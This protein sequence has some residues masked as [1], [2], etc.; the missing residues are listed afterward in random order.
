M[1][2]AGSMRECYCTQFEGRDP[3]EPPPEGRE[4]FRHYVK[5]GPIQ[6]SGSAIRKVSDSRGRSFQASWYVRSFYG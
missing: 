2:A 6:P 1:A 4:E 5:H 3:S